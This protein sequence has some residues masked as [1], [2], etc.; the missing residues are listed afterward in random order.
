MYIY[1]VR[2]ALSAPDGNNFRSHA[3]NDMFLVDTGDSYYLLFTCYVR[4][5]FALCTVEHSPF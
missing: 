4:N 2:S 3:G 5:S 1:V